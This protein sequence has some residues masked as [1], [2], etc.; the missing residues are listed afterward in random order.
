MITTEAAT[1]KTATSPA[2]QVA[3]INADDEKML[4]FAE[5]LRKLEAANTETVPIL[6]RIEANTSL[7]KRLH[8]T[9]SVVGGSHGE[10][11]VA[12]PSARSKA[13]DAPSVAEMTK[14]EPR[15]IARRVAEMPGDN[16]RNPQTV[17]TEPNPPRTTTAIIAAPA[18]SAKKEAQRKQKKY[19]RESGG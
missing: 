9:S 6:K 4:A 2:T 10:S 13:A 7:L 15:A 18:E 16:P 12:V 5:V 14:K 11:R 8:A 1:A 17:I 19:G 3:Q